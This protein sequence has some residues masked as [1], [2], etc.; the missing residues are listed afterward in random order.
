MA[1]MQLLMNQ[2]GRSAELNGTKQGV[3]QPA[4]YARWRLPRCTRRRFT[5][6]A[7]LTNGPVAKYDGTVG[8]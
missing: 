6:A 8:A 2:P 5:T 7:R 1:G 3:R 4:Y